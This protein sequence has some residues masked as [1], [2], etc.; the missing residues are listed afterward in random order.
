M[1]DPAAPLMFA[2]VGKPIDPAIDLKHPDA[3]DACTTY[4]KSRSDVDLVAI[5]CKPGEDLRVYVLEALTPEQFE[6]CQRQANDYGRARQA[7][8]FAWA[9]TRKGASHT[10]VARIAVGSLGDA[11]SEKDMKRVFTEGGASLIREAGD[12]VLQRA[13]GRDGDADPF[14]LPP[15]VRLGF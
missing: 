6:Y 13:E 11:A 3:T 9:E 8:E 2:K 10:K 14:V 5:P 7:F 15:G 1:R 12:L 4:L